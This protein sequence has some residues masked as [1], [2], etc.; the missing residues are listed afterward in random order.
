MVPIVENSMNPVFMRLSSYRR[1]LN[2][3]WNNLWG[4]KKLME[5]KIDLWVNLWMLFLADSFFLSSLSLSFLKRKKKERRTAVKK[6]ENQT[7]G[8]N[9]ITHGEIDLTHG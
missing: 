4:T 9:S 8:R 2:N 3:P 7:H 1:A 5:G 6:H